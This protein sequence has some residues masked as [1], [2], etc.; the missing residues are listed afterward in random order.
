MMQPSAA[1][2]VAFAD[3]PNTAQFLWMDEILH[4]FVDI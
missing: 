4:H 1:R 3:G 2:W